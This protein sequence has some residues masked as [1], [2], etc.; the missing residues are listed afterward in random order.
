MSS[1]S[2]GACAEQCNSPSIALSD[3]A[4][5]WPS[6]RSSPAWPGLASPAGRRLLGLPRHALLLSDQ[7]PVPLPSPPLLTHSLTAHS[8]LPSSD[9]IHRRR[10]ASGSI[11]SRPSVC[12]PRFTE[13]AAIATTGALGA[14]QSARPSLDNCRP[15]P[16]DIASHFRSRC[17]DA[18]AQRTPLDSSAA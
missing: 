5:T 12:R 15:I 17:H 8:F 16:S 3:L 6:A 14:M 11:G 7:P 4:R 18:T 13:H 9:S 1:G 10:S 2:V